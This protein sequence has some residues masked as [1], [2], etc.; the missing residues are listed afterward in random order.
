MRITL[1]GGNTYEVKG[2]FIVEDEEDTSATPPPF[3]RR[4][5]PQGSTPP[6]VGSGSALVGIIPPQNR[7]LQR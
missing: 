6:S 7:L 4:T 2:I 1:P 5:P 3:V